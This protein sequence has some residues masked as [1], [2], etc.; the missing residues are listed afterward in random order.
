MK[1]NLFPSRQTERSLYSIKGTGSSTQYGEIDLREELDGLF[2]SD[3]GIRHGY[4]VVIRHMRRNGNDLVKC[5]CV[6]PLNN[7]A[8]LTCPYCY[9]ERYL[10]DEKWY[11]TISRFSGSDGGL[12]ARKRYMPSGAI[13]VDYKIFYFRYD[14]PIRYSDK[15]VEIKLDEE[16]EVLVPYTREVIY[17]PQTIDK[18]RSDNGR[19]EYIAVH[20][21]EEDAIRLDEFNVNE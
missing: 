15:I 18:H 9:G 16:G 21:R 1:R 12:G 3:N 4:P 2:F 8:S 6:N 19:I 13:R 11:W 17:S 5:S 7:E 14:T 20:C 10:F